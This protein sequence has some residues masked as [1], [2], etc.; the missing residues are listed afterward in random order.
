MSKKKEKIYK[1]SDF[2]E[3]ENILEFILKYRNTFEKRKYFIIDEDYK[4]IKREP[5]FKRVNYDIL[6][7]KKGWNLKDNKTISKIESKWPIALKGNIGIGRYYTKHWLDMGHMTC[8]KFTPNEFISYGSAFLY[9]EDQ[10]RNMIYL[11]EL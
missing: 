6:D 9:C 8:I 2:K 3:V 5:S 11:N 10:N 1:F 4:I 7:S